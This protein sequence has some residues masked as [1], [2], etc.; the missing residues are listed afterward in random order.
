MSK[1]FLE[2]KK[3]AGVA[4]L[5]PDPDFGG[6]QEASFEHSFRINLASV[7]TAQILEGDPPEVKFWFNAEEEAPLHL[8][9]APG[10][11][12]EFERIRRILDGLTLS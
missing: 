2:I 8:S 10:A 3:V 5:V 7:R 4:I 1:L 9:F 11:V 6:V 12:G